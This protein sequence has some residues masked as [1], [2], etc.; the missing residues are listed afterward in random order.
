MTIV[1]FEELDCWKEGRILCTMIYE[2]TSK[3]NKP[4]ASAWGEEHKDSIGL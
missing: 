3:G 2:I 4:H 1:R